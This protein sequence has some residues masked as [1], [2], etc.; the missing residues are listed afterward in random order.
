MVGQDVN[1]IG[2]DNGD[3]VT[4]TGGHGDAL[5]GVTAKFA[6]SGLPHMVHLRCFFADPR[7][8]AAMPTHRPV[9]DAKDAHERRRMRRIDTARDVLFAADE[10]VSGPLRQGTATDMSAGGLR[11]QSHFPESAGTH[12]HIELHPKP[13][14]PDAQV[15]F[16]RGRVMHVTQCGNGVSAMC[17]RIVPRASGASSGSRHGMRSTSTARP[18]NDARRGVLDPGQEAIAA[19]P[20]DADVSGC[21]PRTPKSC[22]YGAASAR[23]C[24]YAELLLPIRAFTWGRSG[25]LSGGH[26]NPKRS[27]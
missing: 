26:L 20:R 22:F 6:R 21:A 13:D 19:A 15:V 5:H 24:Q 12:L 8:S 11:I 7:D 4:A 1:K 3:A 23:P 10:I 16:Y 17:G 27:L 18:I 25:R 14:E 9:D 2:L